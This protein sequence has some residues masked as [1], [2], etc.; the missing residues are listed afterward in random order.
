V[1]VEA[2]NRLLVRLFSPSCKG[3]LKL[4]SAKTGPPKTDIDS[5]SGNAII[6]E[7][8]GPTSPA[9]PDPKVISI[10]P[11]PSAYLNQWPAICRRPLPISTYPSPT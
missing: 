2:G 6:S 9:Q 1:V 3:N 4:D 8:L 10:V 5:T 11:L 7:A